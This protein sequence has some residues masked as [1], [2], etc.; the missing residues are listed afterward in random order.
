[1]HGLEHHVMVGSALLAAYK[2]AGGNINL[3]Q[4]LSE[5][6]ARGTKVPGGAYGF[7]GRM[8]H[9]CEC[10]RDLKRRETSL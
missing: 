9:W 2:N 6:K 4:A 3:A 1:M 10:R 8:W 5:M 7:L